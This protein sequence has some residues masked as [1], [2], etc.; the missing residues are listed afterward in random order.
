[1]GETRLDES[2]QLTYG[3]DHPCA[4]CREAPVPSLILTPDL[5]IVDANDEYLRATFTRRDEIRGCTMFEVFPDNPQDTTADGVRNLRASFDHV[6]R[7]QEP[8]RMAIQRYD[9]RDCLAGDGTWVEKSWAPINLP[10][11]ASGSRELTY[12]IHRV[13]DVTEALYLRR[14]VEE[15]SVV[16]GEQ[17]DTLD[18]MR[19]DLVRRQRQARA[20]QESLATMI[21][22]GRLQEPLVATLRGQF[23]TPDIRRYW[24]PG[25][26]AP[27]TGIYELF[28]HRACFLN[29]RTLFLRAGQPFR[30]CPGCLGSVLYRLMW[31]IR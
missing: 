29:L 5:T 1:M 7:R 28:H 20:A 12:V 24:A 15:Q 31:T 2:K 10:V 17:L 22:A 11:F 14:R 3:I 23:G 30:R 16:I 19:Q 21:G 9:V 4:R 13:E 27:V 6:I 18:R 8:H 25:Q 26:R